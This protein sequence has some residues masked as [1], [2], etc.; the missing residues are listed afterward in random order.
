MIIYHS[1]ENGLE[2][3]KSR[4]KSKKMGVIIGV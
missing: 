3:D 1:V 2:K 4:K